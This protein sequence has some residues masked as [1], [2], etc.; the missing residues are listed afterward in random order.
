MLTDLSIKNLMRPDRRPGK[1]KEVPDGKVAGLYF[2]IQPSGAASWAV[3]YRAAGKPAKLTLGPHSALDLATARKRAKEALGEIAGGKD[4]AAAKRASKAAAKAMAEDRLEVIARDFVEK[5]AKRKAGALWAAETERLLRVEILPK[6]GKKRLGEITKANVHYLLD[7]IVDRGSP[8]TANR[9]LAVLKKLANWSLER[10]L[11]AASPF[12]GLKPP[13]PE[14]ARDRVLSDAE[15]RLAWQAFGSVGEPFGPVGRLL[16][17]TGA[18]LREVAEGRWSEIDLVARTWTIAKERS[19]SGLAHEIPL[20]DKAVEILA[21]LPRMGD[22]KDGFIFTTTGKTP[23]SGFSRAKVSVDTAIMKRLRKDAEECGDNPAGVKGPP[24]WVFHDLRRSCASGMAGIGIAPHVVEAVLAHKSG[25]IKGV[26][27]VY[28]RYS[29]GPEKRAALD[30]WGRKLDEI[31][32][33]KKKPADVADL[34]GARA[35]AV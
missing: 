14:H 16:L 6:L 33:G 31:V 28:N 24:P 22:K 19:K 25:T 32:T 15:L 35:E 26:A 29:Y 4:P 8:T 11:I 3:R 18:R 1:R 10:G 7:G 21:A 20:S 34:V 27:R 23:V 5:H 30:A 12:A 17:L 9:A 13:A 2:V